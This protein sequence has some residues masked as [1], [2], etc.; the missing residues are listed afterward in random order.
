[1]PKRRREPD[2]AFGPALDG[3]DQIGRLELALRPEPEPEIEPEEEPVPPPEPQTAL[4]CGQ[5]EIAL[6]CAKLAAACGFIIKLACK[7][8]PD[9]DDPVAG[10]A[11]EVF[12]LEDFDNL[13]DGCGV[14]STYYITIFT[15][16]AS[17]C[18]HLLYQSLDSDAAYVGAWAGRELKKEVFEKLREDG[19]PD[20]ELAAICCPMGL[21]IGAETP[22]QD[23]VAVVAEML[24]ARSGV[25]KR[26]RFRV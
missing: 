10:L 8:E 14:N 18:E 7:E 26:L 12:V 24:A 16:N 25:L 23:A 21:G 1:M 11:D 4:I 2:E 19:A 22:A 17:D 13:V 3:L 5:G 6:E 15:E 20:A 9:P